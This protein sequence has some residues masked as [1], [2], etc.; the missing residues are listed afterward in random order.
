MVRRGNG[1]DMTK[2]ITDDELRVR[3]GDDAELKRWTGSRKRRNRPAE[4]RGTGRPWKRRS[5]PNRGMI[6]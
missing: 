1:Q 4:T 2:L 5:G 6:K 3:Y